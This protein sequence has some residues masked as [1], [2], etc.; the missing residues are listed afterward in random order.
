MLEEETSESAFQ[1]NPQHERTQINF[2]LTLGQDYMVV[3]T[4]G[5]V[6]T[7][8]TKARNECTDGTVRHFG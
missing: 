3:Q 4:A 6:F 1:T 5:G 2:L 8:T 7:V